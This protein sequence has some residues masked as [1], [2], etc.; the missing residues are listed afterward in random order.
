MACLQVSAKQIFSVH[1]L[2]YVIL[3]SFFLNP[4]FFMVQVFQC[5]G[6]TSSPTLL[7]IFSSVEEE[8]M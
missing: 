2:Y 1:K 6:F 5:P 3:Q 8:K 7:R 4:M